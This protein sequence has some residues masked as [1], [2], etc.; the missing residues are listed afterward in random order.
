ML[1]SLRQT[2]FPRRDGHE[3]LSSVALAKEDR[4]AAGRVTR[5]A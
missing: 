3:C 4:V 2:D 5:P 1:V